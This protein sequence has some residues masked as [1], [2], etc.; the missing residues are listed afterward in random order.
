MDYAGFHL[1]LCL[2]LTA[3]DSN[4]PAS[5]DVSVA[6]SVDA[7][8]ADAFLPSDATLPLDMNLHPEGPPMIRQVMAVESAFVLAALAAFGTPLPDFAPTR[9]EDP[10]TMLALGADPFRIDILTD[11]PGIEFVNAWPRRSKVVLEGVELPLI[12]KADLIAN[13]KAVGRLQD[14][15]DAEALEAIDD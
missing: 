15:A 10:G 7:P 3:C 6:I 4:G 5:Q 14:L 8:M 12:N 11:I 13:K 2:A 1:F 9:F